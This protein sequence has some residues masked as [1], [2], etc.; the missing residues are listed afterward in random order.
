MKKLACARGLLRMLRHSPVKIVTL[1]G[2]K[3]VMV[4]L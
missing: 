2:C 4:F 1:F 3:W